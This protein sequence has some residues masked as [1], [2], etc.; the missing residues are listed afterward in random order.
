M[1]RRIFGEEEEI[2][3]WRKLHKEECHNWCTF[4]SERESLYYL[5]YKYILFQVCVKFLEVS[6][7]WSGVIRF[8]FTCND[9]NNLRYGL[10]KYACPGK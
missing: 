2:R 5:M 6:N 9:P 4:T 8:G 10:P 1:L 7:N 3:G